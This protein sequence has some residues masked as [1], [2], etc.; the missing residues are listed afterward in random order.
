MGARLK[1]RLNNKIILHQNRI[2][3]GYKSQKFPNFF[4]G[5]L[6]NQTE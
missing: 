6:K 5:R 1:F 3:K 2:V 4:E